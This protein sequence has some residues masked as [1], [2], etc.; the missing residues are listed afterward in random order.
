[1]KMDSTPSNGS[2]V[3]A[4]S[5]K[6]TTSQSQAPSGADG[7]VRRGS[8]ATNGRRSTR[9]ALAA[10][11]SRLASLPPFDTYP[12]I[13]IED[14]QPEIDGGRWPIKRV[15][16]DTVEVSADIFK[17][18]HDLFQARVICRPADQ[19]EWHESPMRLV[20]NDRWVG[21]FSVDRNTRHL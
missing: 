10:R 2:S 4:R 18:G 3:R 9:G 20:E 16:G 12:A 7:K 13:A 1:M 5:R 14:V 19:T 6:A 11:E 8:A 17:E 21:S 15:V